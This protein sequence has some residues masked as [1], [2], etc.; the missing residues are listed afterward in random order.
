MPP[1]VGWFGGDSL[2]VER[3]T[4]DLPLNDV[5]QKLKTS[6]KTSANEA[7]SISAHD[8]PLHKSGI[9]SGFLNEATTRTENIDLDSLVSI[10]NSP[11]SSHPTSIPSKHSIKPRF[12]HR[13]SLYNSQDLS[14]ELSAHPI[15]V[16]YSAAGSFY[17]PL[18][19]MFLL[20]VNIYLATKARLRRRTKL[21]KR[22]LMS[23]APQKSLLSKKSFPENLLKFRQNGKALNEKTIGE[24]D[25]SGKNNENKERTSESNLLSSQKVDTEWK[26]KTNSLLADFAELRTEKLNKKD[27]D[28]LTSFSSPSAQI[29]DLNNH[30]KKAALNS[31]LCP[32][33]GPKTFPAVD[34]LRKDHIQSESTVEPAGNVV[35]ET[36]VKRPTTL[37]AN[38]IRGGTGTLRN[39]LE[40]K[41]R[42]SLSLER[43]AAR[44][45]GIIMGAFV[46][47]WLPFF[48]CYVVMPFCP[49]CSQ[50][51][52]QSFISFFVWLGY[53]NS[54]IN[55]LIYTIFNIDYRRAFRNIL[56]YCI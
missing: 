26:F 45:M 42:I 23:V 14:C 50:S 18:L 47:C 15:Y 56:M 6:K 32:L 48:V 8:F 3:Q 34:D 30:Q 11:Y 41:Q 12:S 39:F 54:A 44:T 25:R 36:R 53:I 21:G 20:Y 22:L 7:S 31:D 16:V 43:R 9:I 51:I 29:E 10:S 1:L 17:I 2:Q 52:D 24:K 46:V 49:S 35:S 13:K 38:N 40:E 4:S 37:A 19:I 5:R 55:P 28:S 27:E 33:E